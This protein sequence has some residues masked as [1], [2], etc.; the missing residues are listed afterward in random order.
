[1]FFRKLALT[2]AVTTALSAS[3]LAC[4]T[5]VVGEGATA[6]GSF[7]VARAADSS[8]L[9]A[10][11]FVIHPAKKNQ[12][13]MYRTKDHDG[14]TNFEYPLPKESMRYT[15]V[16]NWKTQLHGA[17]GFNEAGVGISGTESIF[18]RDDALKLD[19]YNEETGI[20]EDDIHDVVLP[21]AKTAR[22]GIE[23]LGSIVETIGAGEGFGVV[24][25]DQKEVWYFETGTGH[26]WMAHRTPKD[27]YFASGNQ[28]RLQQ[29][30]A[31]S[32]DFMASKTLVSWAEK[33]GFYD[34]K[35]DGEF[36][37]SKAYCR[38][39]ARDRVYNDPRVWQIQKLFNPSLEQK[40]DEGRTYPVYLKPEK[41]LTVDD[42]K[43][44]LR[45][46]Y[47]GTDH[48]PYSPVLNGNEPWRPISVFRT[49]ESHIMQVRPW[50]PQAI[51]CLIH[52]AFGMADLSVYLPF[53]QGLEA[54][55][56]HYG[57]GTDHCD[58]RS[59][60][61]KFRRLQ[62]LV[63][64]DY[65]GLAPMV[66]TAFAKFEADLAPRMAAF[67]AEFVKLHAEDEKAAAKLLNDFNLRVLAE[68]E[69]LCET[70]L[71]DC[72]TKRTTD[73]QEA[74]YFRNRKAKD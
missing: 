6:D 39:D 58:R 53:Y 64:T 38:D 20:T 50:L 18:A 4:T 23:I 29:Y 70:L 49:Y 11:H 60:Y 41:K 8:A 68:G 14:A 17:V 26:Q 9:K 69:E 33:N 59:V 10:Q 40:P 35:K 62:T 56:Q 19:P 15:T 45:N 43:T 46:H 66:K 28:G 36:N 30:D 42:M 55:P 54:V 57:C 3:A 27:T 32:A 48:D 24:F 16:P 74:V 2:L 21:R 67:E 5:V 52:L 72:F 7:L 47:E 25:V 1:M 37:F 12:S 73:I 13:G 65:A 51:G 34:P 63:M 61:W 22:E 44:M 71:D 31:K